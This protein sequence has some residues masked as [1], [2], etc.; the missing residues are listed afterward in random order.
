MRERIGSSTLLII[1]NVSKVA[2]LTSM[3]A[4]ASDAGGDK[5][6]TIRFF[7][8]IAD[9]RL[10]GSGRSSRLV[11]QF[12]SREPLARNSVM[13]WLVQLLPEEDAL[14]CSISARS[15]ADCGTVMEY[16]PIGVSIE[17]KKYLFPACSKLNCACPV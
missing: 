15:T 3:L 1:R 14:C 8:R 11:I 5:L 6:T 2:L 9:Q 13:T 17:L 4:F 12:H 10:S 16:V 7:Y